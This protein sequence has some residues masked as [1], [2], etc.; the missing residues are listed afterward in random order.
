MRAVMSVVAVVLAVVLL[1]WLAADRSPVERS[2]RGGQTAANSDGP[3]VEALG[4]GDE[5]RSPAAATAGAEEPEIVFWQS[6][7]NSTNPVEFEAYL[8]QFPDGVFRALAET[9]L[10]A[11]RGTAGFP[12]AAAR[13]GDGGRGALAAGSRASGTP[14]GASAR[15]ADGAARPQAR[16]AYHLSVTIHG[17]PRGCGDRHSFA[18]RLY[19][20]VDVFD[21]ELERR[22]DAVERRTQ[23]TVGAI[24]MTHVEWDIEELVERELR[25][26][27][28]PFS[29]AERRSLARLREAKQVFESDPLA[30]LRE[31]ERARE[32]G[33]DPPPMLWAF[34]PDKDALEAL[35][36]RVPLSAS[37]SVRLRQGQE[38]LDTWN[39]L[40]SERRGMTN[41]RSMRVYENERLDVALFE[42][43]FFA[44][45]RCLVATVMLDRAILNRGSLDLGGGV[46][47][48]DFA[49]VP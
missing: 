39:R 46:L 34:S 40:K 3:Q 12:A 22:I 28:E 4:A 23:Q 44:D 32:Q 13:S 15:P 21:P 41:P 36:A 18:D 6:V 1:A 8:E 7:V 37:E 33:R 9:R 26:R 29:E 20:R 10:E 35:E 5:S 43:D 31:A 16:Q 11:L 19:T 49:A 38:L 42:E 48:L 24:S 47:S 17:R 30:R 14:V 27:T 25:S 2:A 45:D